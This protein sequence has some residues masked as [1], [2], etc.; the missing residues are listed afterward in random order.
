MIKTIVFEIQYDGSKF[1][2]WQHQIDK[3]TI[4]NEFEKVL[5]RI[6]GLQL[7]AIISG[8]TDTGVH[9]KAQV[10]SI[11]IPEEISHQIKVP[12]TKLKDVVNNSLPSDIW[13]NKANYLDFDFNARFD[14]TSREYSY[15][16]STDD[17]VFDFN[18]KM[19]I[20]KL[21]LA[22][23][24]KKL[25]KINLD[26]LNEVAK[27]FVGKHDFTT[28]SK[29]NPDVKHYV[30]DIEFSY[31]EQINEFDYAYRVKANR[32]VY[33]MVRNLVANMLITNSNLNSKLNS[34]PNSNSF[35][36][37]TPEI[38]KQNL[39]AKDR[40]LSFGLAPA[41]GL[42]FEKVYFP[43]NLKLWFEI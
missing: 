16:I 29:F 27:I 31:W 36:K 7:K 18:Y 12:V 10:I 24:I 5:N 40:N 6:F 13:V 17:N 25:D 2:G 38:I 34:N 43:D 15:I 37:I 35:S 23:K 19:Q 8:R 39:E 11:N 14:A 26:L 33:S 20:K 32:F 3:R 30:C 9:A 42:Y 22:Q 21:N 41:N 1:N 4:Q 28:F